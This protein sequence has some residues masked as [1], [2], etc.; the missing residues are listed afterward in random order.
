MRIY[1]RNIADGSKGMV[2]FRSRF[3]HAKGIAAK[4]FV[5]KKFVANKFAGSMDHTVL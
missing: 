4:G 2:V 5:A 1:L 3:F